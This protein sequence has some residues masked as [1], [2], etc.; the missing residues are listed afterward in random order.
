M[1]YEAKDLNKYL[2]T[3]IA[4]KQNNSNT[5]MQQMLEAYI[6]VGGMFKTLNVDMAEGAA[7]LGILAIEVKKVL[8]LVTI[9]IQFLLT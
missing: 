5:S 6:G 4:T 2:D 8:K 7:I 3:V 9:L 1:G